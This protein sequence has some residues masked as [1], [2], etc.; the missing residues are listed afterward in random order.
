MKEKIQNIELDLK[1]KNDKIIDLEKTVESYRARSNLLYKESTIQGEG[2]YN[3]L[4]DFTAGVKRDMN[5][6]DEKIR[7][8]QS[9]SIQMQQGLSSKDEEKPEIIQKHIEYDTTITNK[10]ERLENIVNEIKIIVNYKPIL[11]KR[12]RRIIIKNSKTID[13]FVRLPKNYIPV[14]SRS[15]F[16]PKIH[17]EVDGMFKCI[18][19]NPGDF[20]YQKKRFTINTGNKVIKL[21]REYNPNMFINR[22]SIKKEIRDL[23]GNELLTYAMYMYKNRWLIDIRRK[24]YN[25]KSFPLL[26]SSSIVELKDKINY[27]INKKAMKKITKNAKHTN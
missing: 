13:D 10:I 1:E 2:I 14:I 23:S 18:I 26:G 11:P 16:I 22:R 17:E 15:V 19:T 27:V 7:L 5:I 12:E 6:L 25:L 4:D 3:K 24:N 20:K 8:V 9:K 21:K